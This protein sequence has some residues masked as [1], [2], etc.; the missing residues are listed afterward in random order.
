[1]LKMS[2]NLNKIEKLLRNIY[3]IFFVLM[4]I[5]SFISNFIEID[6]IIS[7]ENIW[8]Y[9]ANIGYIIILIYIIFAIYKNIKLGLSKQILFDL[10]KVIIFLILIP[11]NWFI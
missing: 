6:N 4:F 11:F 1:M 7:Y 2:E 10:I 3:I 5:F 9:M 8:V